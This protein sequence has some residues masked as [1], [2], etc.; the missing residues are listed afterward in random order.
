MSRI[1]QVSPLLLAG[2]SLLGTIVTVIGVTVSKLQAD[3]AWTMYQAAEF[4]DYNYEQ[5]QSAYIQAGNVVN[6][7]GSFV[8][9]GVLGILLTLM[10]FSLHP[11][12][13]TP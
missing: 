12:P 9:L 2:V 4:D 1:Y 3:A 13:A 8:L 7:W 11:R 6:A 5:L 10:V